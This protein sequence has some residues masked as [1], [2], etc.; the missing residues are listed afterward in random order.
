MHA[1]GDRRDG[2]FRAP[3]VLLDRRRPAPHLRPM[4]LPPR[5]RRRS[6]PPG[7]RATT[8][9]PRA[10]ARTRDRPATLAAD[11]PALTEADVAPLF[12]DRA[13]RAR[14]VADLEAGRRRRPPGR[15]R[16]PG[17]ARPLPRRGRVLAG[18][19]ARRGAPAAGRPRAR[20]AR[21]RRSGPLPARPGARRA[22]A[23]GAR[24][25]RPTGGAGALAPLGRGA[26]RP[27]ARA[28][29][30][31]R[32]R[33]RS[34]ALLPLIALTAPGRRAAPS[35]PRRCSSPAG[36]ARGA[37]RRHFARRAFLECWA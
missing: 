21:P 20:A 6:A 8:A 15:S 26:P 35:A 34:S 22:P 27:R 13:A 23:A 17:A 25:P 33:G 9:P 37:E 16:P 30:R 32:R 29:R 3:G 24:R 14:P 18:R 4:L 19:P 5:G 10:R 12:R 36:C 11:D 28:R 31:R 7:R 1:R 2:G